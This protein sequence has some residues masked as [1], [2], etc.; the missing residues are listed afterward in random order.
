MSLQPEDLRAGD[1]VLVHRHP[2]LGPGP[3]PAEP[4]GTVKIHPLAEAGHLAR[5][6][7][8]TSGRRWF[9][10]VVFDEPQHDA[11][12]DGPYPESEILDRY[13]ERL[14]RDLT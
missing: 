2:T 13:L 7:D 3:W 8:T 5:A 4:S 11:E 12:G 1:R 6:T 14:D 9:Y 10:W